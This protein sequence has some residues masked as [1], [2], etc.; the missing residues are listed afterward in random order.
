MGEYF[1]MFLC[2]IFENFFRRQGY[3]R[4]QN[5]SIWRYA[6]FTQLL[7]LKYGFSSDLFAIATVVSLIIMYDASG[8][9]Q[10]VGKQAT[11]L[12]QLIEDW[13]KKKE[14][15]QEKLKELMG[16][17]PKQVFFGALLGIII[18]LIF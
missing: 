15:K 14:I 7:G 8:V 9:R 13:Q 1:C 16:H 12:N 5:N 6:K 10:A 17:T 18:G 11:I 4:K 2:S 3:R